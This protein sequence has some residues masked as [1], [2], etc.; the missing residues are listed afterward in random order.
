MTR[1]FKSLLAERLESDFQYHPVPFVAENDLRPSLIR[2]KRIRAIEPPTAHDTATASQTLGIN[3]KSYQLLVE[4]GLFDYNYYLNRYP[5]IA[6]AGMDPL[7]H[8]LCQGYM[9]RREPNAIFDANYYIKIY[10]LDNSATFDALLHY[11]Q[12]GEALGYKP[13]KLFD[14]VWYKKYYRLKDEEGVLAHYMTHR[15]GPFSPIP[16]F[17]ASY[18]LK[19]YPDIA[20]AGIDPFE[21]YINYGYTEG[22]N[23]SADFDTKYYIKRYLNGKLDVNPLVHYIENRAAG[24]QPRASDNDPSIPANVKRFTKPGPHFEDHRPIA[25]SVPRKAKVLAYYLTQFHAFPENDRWWGKGFTEWTNV[26]RGLPRFH[27]HFQPRVPRDG[28]FYNLT[29][30]D[31]MRRQCEAAKTGGVYGFVFYYYWFNGKRLMEKPLEAFLRS[32]DIDM[33]FCLMW[34]NESWTRRWDG[35]EGEV[36]ISQ[37]YSEADDAGL[38]ADYLRHFADPRY[39]RVAGRPLLMVYR[40][41][42]IPETA[43]T[44]AKWRALFRAQGGE[45]PIMIMSQSFDDYDPQEFGLDGAIEFPPHKITKKTKLI[46]DGLTYLDDSFSGQVYD[47]EDVVR[48]SLEEP[49]PDFPLI[50]TVVPSWDND[51]RRQ[52]TGLVIQGSTPK[53]YEDWLSKLV[54]QAQ[55]TPFFGE[56]IV[57]INAWNEWCEGAYLEADLH[58]GSAYLNATGRAVT[59]LTQVSERPRLVLIGHDAFQ[60]G[61][62]MLILNIGRRLKTAYGL[63]IEFLLLGGG[64]LEADYSAVAP[65]ALCLDRKVVAEKLR[66]LRERGFTAVIGNTSVSGTAIDM[67]DRLGYR[68]VMLVHELPRIIREKGLAPAAR[69]GLVS[70]DRVVFPAPSIRDRL[71]E[72]LEVRQSERFVVRPQG[73]YHTMDRNSVA[74]AEIRRELGLTARDRLILGVGY[75]DMRKGFDLF[76]Q[77]WRLV[78]M[79]HPEAHFC[80]VGDADPSMMDWLSEEIVDAEETGTFHMAG[81]RRDVVGFFSAASAYVLT[82]RE[83]PFPTVALEA[84]S[85]E[86]P[87]L[88]F[89]RTG[90]IP[91][92]MKHYG[93]GHVLPYG[94]VTAMAERLA[95]LLGARPDAAMIARGREVVAAEFNFAGYVRD[96]LDF[97]LPNLAS[98]SVVVPNYKY[99]P[100]LP[101]RLA[102]IFTQ[103][104]PVVEIIVLDD[105][106]PDDSVAVIMATA[107]DHQRDIDLVL[108]VEN[109]GSVFKQWRKGAERAQGDYVWIAEADDLSDPTFLSRL[110]AV[111]ET[112]PN[113][114]MGFTDS[115]SI[116]MEGAPVYSTYKGYYDTVE[117]GA[118]SEDAVYDGQEFVRRFLSVK[119][120]ILNVSSVMWRKE[121]LLAVLQACEKELAELRMAGDWRVYLQ[122]LSRHNA[123]IAYVAEPLNVHRRHA[124]SVTHALNAEKHLGEISAMQALV[125]T[126]GNTVDFRHRQREYLKEVTAQML[127]QAD[128]TIENRPIDV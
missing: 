34:A 56:P 24:N 115:R 23:P 12:S 128:L 15:K 55:R 57:C 81:F 17:D 98:I 66:D 107:E 109:S 33:P 51:A 114:V 121:A 38:V 50:K 46:N 10:E 95:G 99:A 72:A 1:D 19:S 67:A 92:M 113:I 37:D 126:F 48:V 101:A 68:T 41:R 49:T 2:Y 89:D 58:F 40:P 47:Y 70:A 36:L 29:D 83:D 39:I 84:M 110:V 28:G 3:P 117:R 64:K 7:E 27:G 108:N 105:A 127:L 21:H 18:Y 76:L 32:R 100:V 86:V 125:A 120:L 20:A 5:D 26:P 103:T 123:R 63:E 91:D 118:L 53:L 4:S 44:I 22:R 78:R 60:A 122:C 82:S 35:L 30:I 8:Y 97:A 88:A 42:L 124:S 73:T 79:S 14:P 119:N 93:I 74:G 9:E 112:D 85:A 96:V 61:A 77:L 65:T 87:V 102:T 43:A 13:N 11:I 31:V 80:W 106:S 52:S 25:K 6:Q 104:Y 45:D 94:S 69:D 111:M 90:G 75:A 71:V 54:D 62:Q 116:D 59:G 16:D